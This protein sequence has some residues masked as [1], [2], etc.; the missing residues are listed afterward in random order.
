MTLALSLSLHLQ[1]QNTFLQIINQ[2]KSPKIPNQCSAFFRLFLTK[3]TKVVHLILSTISVIFSNID[4]N[5]QMLVLYIP[6][7]SYQIDLLPR[8][9]SIKINNL[10]I[11][12]SHPRHISM[13]SP[14]PSNRI[15]ITLN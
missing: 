12:L 15:K 5:I 1:K 3:Q 7:S 10:S 2:L 8:P 6:L 4:M 13:T 14:Q 11:N 9:L